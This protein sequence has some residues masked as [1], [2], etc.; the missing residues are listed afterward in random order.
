M[1]RYGFHGLSYKYIAGRLR[2]LSPEAARG[3][4]LVAHLGSGA[5]MCALQEGRSVDTSMG[6]SALDGLVMGTRCG[7]LDPGVLL[8]LL[9]QGR[10]ASAVE[11]MLYS[12]AGLL[13]VSGISAD[14]RV[15]LTNK[16]AG[17]RGGGRS[18]CLPCRPEAAALA[19]SMN[20]LDGIVFTAGIGENSPE[21]RRRICERLAWLGLTL[22]PA[23][24]EANGLAIQASSS[25]IQAWV[26]PTDEELMIARHTF[27]LA[28]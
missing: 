5:S 4:V 12:H 24:N 22:E 9:R 6:F 10:S 17:A 3:R 18:L 28:A 21:I 11:E 13:G 27:S 20:G 8:Y 25:R 1:R 15:L 19:S 2:E 7:A 16:S 23:A 14:M 26:L